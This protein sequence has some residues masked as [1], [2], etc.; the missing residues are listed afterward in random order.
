MAKIHHVSAA[1]VSGVDFEL[2]GATPIRPLRAVLLRSVVSTTDEL[3]IPPL[4][5]RTISLA[6]TPDQAKEVAGA[7][8]ET[9][10]Q[11]EQKPRRT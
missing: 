6:L 7:L 2:D 5:G 9:V 1:Q 3:P 11:L 8:L 10:R 4:P